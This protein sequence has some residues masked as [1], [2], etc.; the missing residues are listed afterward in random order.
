MTL[1]LYPIPDEETSRDL[2]GHVYSRPQTSSLGVLIP[3]LATALRLLLDVGV[4]IIRHDERQI[5]LSPEATGGIIIVVVDELLP[6]DP[7]RHLL[8]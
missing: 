3:D 6:G 1:A 5:V 8:N 4:P 2:W 7:R